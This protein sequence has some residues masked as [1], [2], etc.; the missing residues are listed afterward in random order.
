MITSRII[1]VVGR[2]RWLY[3]S[4]DVMM[5]AVAIDPE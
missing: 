3:A 4:R 2:S 1:R 5:M